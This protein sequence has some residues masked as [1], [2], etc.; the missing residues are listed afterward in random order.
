MKQL[1]L[2]ALCVLLCNNGFSQEYMDIIAKESCEC[3]DRIQDTLEEEAY[4][5]EIGICMIDA[6][7]PYKKRLKKD[8]DINLDKID[9]A[10]EELGRLIGLKMASVCPEALL[11]M[12]Q[13]ANKIEENDIEQSSRGIVTK[14]EDDFFV[15][16]SS[17][18]ESGRITKYYWLTFVESE[19]DLTNSYETLVGKSVDIVY[20]ALEFFDPRILEYR[21]FLIIK[22]ITLIE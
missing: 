13:R 22:K 14:V 5:F 17:Q 16:I 3:F 7:M 19:Q 21:Q 20:E 15:V 4:F 8:Y 2:I 11:K 6:S 12:T 9:I 18:D 10:A 1:L